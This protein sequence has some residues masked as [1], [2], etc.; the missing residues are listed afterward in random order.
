MKKVLLIL[1][2]MIIFMC[3][4]ANNLSETTKQDITINIPQ[5][6]TVN[7]YR[8]DDSSMPDEIPASEVKPDNTTSFTY[9]G[10]K[11]SKKFHK[12]SCSYLKNTNDSNK[13][14]YKTKEEFLENNF[15][16]CKHC[17]P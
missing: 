17:N 7:G 13:V 3:G 12:I 8:I 2:C 5:D 9:C 14:Y 16:A 1:L 4:C 15:V 10:N 6:D 11:N